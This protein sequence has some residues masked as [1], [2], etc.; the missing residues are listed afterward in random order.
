LV[1][2]EVRVPVGF[3][4]ELEKLLSPV[5]AGVDALFGDDD[6]P[7]PP[8]ERVQDVLP[9]APWTGPPRLAGPWGDSGGLH[10]GADQAAG[11]YQQSS[12]TVAA[13]DDKLA[14]LLKEIFAANDETRA[15]VGE[16]VAG[17]QALHQKMMSDPAMSR[18]P[19]A[20]AMFN[21]ILD[22]YLAEI[23]RLLNSAK[24]DSKKQAEL[25]AA[26]GDDYRDGSGE[27]GKGGTD[28][29]GSGGGGPGGGGSGGTDGGAAGGGGADPGVGAAGAVTDPLAGMA[30][31]GVMGDPTSMLGPALGALGSLPGALGGAG[32]SLPMDALGAL[33]PLAGAMGTR[34]GSGDA[35]TDDG[36]RER[37]KPADFVDDHHGHDEEGADGGKGTGGKGDN[38]RKPDPA[39]AGA[40]GVQ[41]VAA[42]PAAAAAAPATAP[43]GDASLVVRMPDGTPVTAASP[44][45]A[46]VL[47]AVLSG[48]SATDAW[49]PYAQLPPPGTPVAMPADPSHLVPGQVAQC[50]SREAIVY[51]G[52]GKIW[53]D[54]QLQ[55]QSALP[56]AEFMG[57]EDP[58]QFTGTTPGRVPAAMSSP[59]PSPV[60]AGA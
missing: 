26:L 56:A 2:G 25:L 23:Q 43:G 45:H 14:K 44:Q 42:Q 5:L 31:P 36:A 48:A 15:R 60:P 17:I 52:N 58:I 37:G 51:M 3:L 19:R 28:A 29:G 41:P 9:T 35:F 21:T 22:Q 55:P 4:E 33:A 12:G 27:R 7:A 53:L 34:R 24:V 16:L 6:E 38:E 49:R 13:T 20:L 40:A 59:A 10:W 47:R 57:W 54:G 50:K 32:G 18:D 39:A 8:R 1:D 30:M 11:T 46:A